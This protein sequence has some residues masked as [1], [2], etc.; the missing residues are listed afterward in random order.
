MA[1]SDSQW[2]SVALTGSQWQSVAVCGSQWQPVAASGSQWQL[3][4]VR[5]SQLKT[6]ISLSAAGAKV[7]CAS[8][9][10]TGLK[11]QI[12]NF[13]QKTCLMESEDMLAV[14]I[15]ILDGIIFFVI[16]RTGNQVHF[17]QSRTPAKSSLPQPSR[18]DTIINR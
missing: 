14:L 5:N 6:C 16:G 18:S 11:F 8:L 10:A 2:Q 13:S 15:S 3:M 9:S 7:H 1:V 12:S 17:G 4:A